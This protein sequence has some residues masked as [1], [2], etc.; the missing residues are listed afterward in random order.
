MS[1]FGLQKSVQMGLNNYEE[2]MALIEQGKAIVSKFMENF[3]VA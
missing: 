3:F 1:K 2:F